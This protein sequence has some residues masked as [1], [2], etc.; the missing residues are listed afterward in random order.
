MCCVEKPPIPNTSQHLK[1]LTA[2]MNNNYLEEGI[3]QLKLERGN[4][5]VTLISAIY[6]FRN[7]GAD[8]IGLEYK[9][10]PIHP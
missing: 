10:K 2:Y 7:V 6:L 1:T 5:L 4:S 3:A 9:S 8:A